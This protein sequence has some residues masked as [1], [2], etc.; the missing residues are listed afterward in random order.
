MS[1]RHIMAVGVEGHSFGSKVARLASAGSEGIDFLFV[2]TPTDRL[3]PNLHCERAD[4]NTNGSTDGSAVII[5]FSTC[6]DVAAT[7]ILPFVNAGFS[8]SN[9]TEPE[10]DHVS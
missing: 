4:C 3:P 1:C 7:V 2:K 6:K 5:G 10:K 8:G 9:L